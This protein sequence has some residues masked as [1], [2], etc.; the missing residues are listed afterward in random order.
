MSALAG[1]YMTFKLASEEY[2]VPI[3]AVR[4]LIG[5]MEITRVPQ[6]PAFVRGVINLRGKVIPV[7]DL[8]AKFGMSATVSTDQTVIIVVQLMSEATPIILGVLVDEVLEVLDIAAGL[9]EPAPVFGS[10]AFE[11]DFILGVGKAEARVI[12]LLDIEKVL[13]ATE[14]AALARVSG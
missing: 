13:A 3:L 4:E 8:K 12:F 2:G 11:T 5:I 1:K 14:K 9:I 7:I 6:A 10:A